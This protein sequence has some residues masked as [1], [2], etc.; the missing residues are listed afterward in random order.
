MIPH[1]DACHR[2]KDPR[3][4]ACH[5]VEPTRCAG[6]VAPCWPLHLDG[7]P[8]VVRPGPLSPGVRRRPSG[9]PLD[10]MRTGDLAA[11]AE[12]IRESGWDAEV[13][14]APDTDGQRAKWRADPYTRRKLAA[15]DDIMG[16]TE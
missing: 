5:A 16:R 1:S 9:G 3:C 12:R 8:R 13:L 14:V 11:L 10:T 7:P 4:P 15:E 2:G 6:Y